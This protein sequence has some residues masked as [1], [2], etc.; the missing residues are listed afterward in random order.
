GEVVNKGDQ[1]LVILT[2]GIGMKVWTPS[3]VSDAA[4]LGEVTYLYTDLILRENDVNLYGF[5][6][7][8]TRD[9][10]RTLVKINGVG[11]KA[12]LSILSTLTLQ[13]IY[14]AVFQK[15]VQR[16][17]LVHGIGKKTAQKIILYLQDELGPLT[18]VDDGFTSPVDID[19]ELLDALVGLGYSIVEAQAS[20]Q[21]LPEDVE[22]DLETRLRLALRYFS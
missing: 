10:F 20:I 13:N 4:E 9:L 2:G 18:S 5:I 11:P 19:T 1:Y 15:D 7:A 14:Q 3:L 16:F 22:D 6:E 12:A 8:K 21:S 17:I